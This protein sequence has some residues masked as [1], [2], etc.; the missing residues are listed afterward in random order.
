MSQP[1]DN[2]NNSNNVFVWVAVVAVLLLSFYVWRLNRVPGE[3][4][5]VGVTPAKKFSIQRVATPQD[6]MLLLVPA[7][8][9]PVEMVSNGW[10]S[11]KVTQAT[12]VG[13]V[14]IEM[15]LLVSGDIETVIVEIPVKDALGTR[16]TLTKVVP[17]EPS[18]SGSIVGAYTLQVDGVEIKKEGVMTISE[19]AGALTMTA[20]EHKLPLTPAGD[21]KWEGS[22]SPNQKLVF[23]LLP[24]G[25]VDMK[26]FRDGQLRDQGEVLLKRVPV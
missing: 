21:N 8:K 9:D 19:V 24:S 13:N 22:D 7:G 20:G 25:D 6:S 23:T 11:W 10:A 2:A 17:A 16:M 26:K 14:V 15:T 1:A 18:K 12:L 4:V 5:S 3:Y